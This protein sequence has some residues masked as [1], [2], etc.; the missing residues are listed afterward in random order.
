MMFVRANTSGGQS[1]SSSLI[2]TPAAASH[3]EANVGA[4]T[5]IVV[6]TSQSLPSSMQ[7]SAPDAKF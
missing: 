1:S 5:L 4:G 6:E 7:E 3:T 2:S